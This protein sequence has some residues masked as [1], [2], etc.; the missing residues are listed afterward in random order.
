MSRLN[1]FD[2]LCQGNVSVKEF[3][4]KFDDLDVICYPHEGPKK[5]TFLDFTWV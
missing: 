3:M 1:A 2:R 5:I 4:N